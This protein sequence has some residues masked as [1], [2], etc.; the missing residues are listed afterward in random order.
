MNKKG[1]SLVELIAVIVI[2]GIIASVATV[3]AVAVI[4]RQKKN[5]AI[6]SLNGIY[7]SAIAL[8]VQVETG[9]FDENIIVEDSYCYI[10][11]TTL[12]DTGNVEGDDYRP[13]DN[14]IYFC[15]M[16]YKPYVIIGNETPTSSI[17][18]V[19]GN[20]TINGVS[21]TFNYSKN[22]FVTA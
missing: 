3:T 4:D 12:I 13:V 11:L 15:Y 21:I 18:E 19:T 6:N 17:P 5:A 10:S 7:D 1:S 16:Q 8:L 14:E 2:M 22:Q 20:S 9:S